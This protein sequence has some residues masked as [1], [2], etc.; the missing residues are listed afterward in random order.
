MTLAWE[1]KPK[2]MLASVLRKA[3]LL[4]LALGLGS[5]ACGDVA[6]PPGVTPP[7]GAGSGGSAGSSP[8]TSGRGGASSAG[9]AGSNSSKGGSTGSSGGD[10]GTAGT[11][12]QSGGSG[13]APPVGGELSDCTTPGPRLI[14]R[15][16]SI[17]YRNT[18]VDA[19]GDPNLPSADVLTDPASS[20]R[21]RVD[22]DL[23]S[24]AIS[25]RA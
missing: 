2:T 19:F 11:S 4:V 12:S 21:F 15:L 25:M 9:S 17:Q 16:S 7:D 24:C 18:L 10:T 6:S 8:G 1:S 13:G 20:L 3:P 22:A 23:P 14:R 5:V